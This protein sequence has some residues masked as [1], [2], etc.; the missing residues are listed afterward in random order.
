MLVMWRWMR[1][2]VVG[3]LVAGVVIR[4]AG[5]QGV[6][7]E[8]RISG[9]SMAPT[10]IGEH[11][12]LICLDCGATSRYDATDP[13]RDGRVIC[14]NCGA[15]NDHPPNADIFAGQ[16]VW[17][18][19]WAYFGRAPAR[20]EIVALLD[21]A[22]A[23]RLVV[24]RIVGLPGERIEFRHGD[25]VAD[26][27]VV[28]KSLVQLRAMAVLVH[29][30]THQPRSDA[31]LPPRWQSES[32]SSQW[33]S[34]G[35]R[36]VFGPRDESAES[37]DWI[38]YQHWPCYAGIVPRSQPSPILDNDS[39]NQ[40]LSRPLNAVT[41]V[42]LACRLRTSG[43]AGRVALEIEVRSDRYR[44]E[45]CF[46]RRELALFRNS[47]EL[48]RSPLLPFAFARG[49][50]LELAW[51]DGQLLLGIDRH[52]LI[53]L[54]MEQNGTGSDGSGLPASGS[55]IGRQ[56]SAPRIAIGAAGRA[57]VVDRLRILRDVHYLPAEFSANRRRT[58][59]QL[60]ADQVFLVGDNVPVSQ[61]SRHWARPGL[62]VSRILGRVW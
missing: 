27:R 5:W 46:D 23:S 52:E 16:R 58:F 28:R 8:V 43:R 31:A 40:Q 6:C 41:D 59:T 24:K 19:R 32:A 9:P 44:A 20:W 61:D 21:P 17:I 35:P 33:R 42:M 34:D 1:W 4:L 36:L 55:S 45:L 18:D 60:G 51:C 38:S 15:V 29:D 53:R 22:D 47:T 57:V 50:M 56:G 54:A 2:V 30:H 10:R 12:R 49:V 3:L 62:P 26:G 14:W 39:Y 13:P 7:S 25:L 11:H 37:L 48:S